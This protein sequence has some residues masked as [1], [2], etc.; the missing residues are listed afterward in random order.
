MVAS[1]VNSLKLYNM[2]Y[3]VYECNYS[4]NWKLML[5]KRKKTRILER[6]QTQKRGQMGVMQGKKTI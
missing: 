4:G 3:F 6:R 5:L 2:S 1:I